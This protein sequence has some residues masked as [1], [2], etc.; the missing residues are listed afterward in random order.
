MQ[1]TKYKTIMCRYIQSSKHCPLGNR[2]H[3]A[4]SKDE[5]RKKEDK[6]PKNA[7]IMNKQFTTIQSMGNTE[8]VV[9]AHNYKTV[10]CK[11][12]QQD[13]CKFQ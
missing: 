1:N 2:C 12:W 5:I 7:P 4:H 13:K 10:M 6:L 9:G 8:Q 3:F 11:Y